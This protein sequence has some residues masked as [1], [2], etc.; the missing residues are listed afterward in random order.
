MNEFRCKTPNHMDNQACDQAGK[1]AGKDSD[2]RSHLWRAGLP[3][4]LVS[5]G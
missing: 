5:G 3:L 2:Q 4:I 1:R